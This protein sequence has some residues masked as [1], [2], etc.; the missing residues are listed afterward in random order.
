MYCTRT[1]YSRK[2]ARLALDH[3]INHREPDHEP[4][5]DPYRKPGQ[6]PD[7]HPDH[8]HDRD[9]G[10]EPFTAYPHAA[11]GCCGPLCVRHLNGEKISNELA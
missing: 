7:H 1:R 6:D 3:T 11:R 8:D 5:S 9:P 2:I 10:P 4:Y